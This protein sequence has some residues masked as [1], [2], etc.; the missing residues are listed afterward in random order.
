LEAQNQRLQL[1][2]SAPKLDLSHRL[3]ELTKENGHLRLEIKFYRD[4][5]GFAQQFRDVVEQIAQELQIEYFL[6]AVNLRVDE[7]VGQRLSAVDTLETSKGLVD[8]LRKAVDEFI[9]KQGL[10]EE[11]WLAFWGSG[12]IFKKHAPRGMI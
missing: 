3:E 4:C 6:S 10:V 5:F 7:S 1:A 2:K 8:S 11:A 12:D 9:R